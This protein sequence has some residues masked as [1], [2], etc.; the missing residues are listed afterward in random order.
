M[1]RLETTAVRALRWVLDQQP[2]TDAKVAFAWRIA[3]GQTFSR[4]A[5]VTWSADGTLRV[6]ARSDAWRHEIS[7]ARPVLIARIAELLG[8]GVVKRITV[9][10]EA[11]DA[12]SH[13]R[14]TS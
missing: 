1:Q 8:P 10:A 12:F 5:S 6:I 2:V 9:L 13:D 14:R 11:D 7:R 3:A 4:A